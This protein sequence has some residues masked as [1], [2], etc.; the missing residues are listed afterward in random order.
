MTV[1]A[2]GPIQDRPVDLSFI[3]SLIHHLAVATA[4]QF[5]PRPLCLERCRGGGRLMAL[6][7]L[8][9][10][11]WG[12]HIRKQD[13]PFIRTVRVVAGRTVGFSHR[14]VHMLP[15]EPGA[16]CF[17]ATCTEGDQIVFQK[18]FR[19]VRGMRGVAVDAPLVHRRMLEFSFG[20]GFTDLLMA[21]QTELIA[22]F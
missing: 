16:I 3:K 21:P 19:L 11:H 15:N 18:I 7:A 1:K 20:N 8:P 12:M 9:V 5:K 10:G 6:V 14:I 4:A 13:S 22:W 17:V 2:S